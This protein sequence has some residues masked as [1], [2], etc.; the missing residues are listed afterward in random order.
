MHLCAVAKCVLTDFSLNWYRNIK[1]EFEAA[2]KHQRWAE[3]EWVKTAAAVNKQIFNAAKW[4]V[5]KIVHKIPV[6][7]VCLFFHR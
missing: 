1:E 6:L 2:E 4:L 3:R 7:R 5:A